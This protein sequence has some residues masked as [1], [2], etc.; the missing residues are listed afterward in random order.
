MTTILVSGL[1]NIETTLRVDGFP[2]LYSPV[3]Y[4]FWGV[5]AT[6]SGVGY[7]VAK[8]LTVLGDNVRFLSLI[9]DDIAATT[10]YD[11]LQVDGIRPGY[12]LATLEETPRSVILYDDTGKRQI[13]VDLK[14]VQE[15]IYPQAQ[16]ESAIAGCALA[17]LCNVNFSRPFLAQCRAR[18]IPIAT[19][20]HAIGDLE[21]EYDADFMAG[22]DILFMSHESLPCPPEEWLRRLWDRYGTPI[23][24]IGKGAEGALLGLKDSGRILTFPAVETRPRV[25]TVGAGDAMFSAFVHHYALTHDPEA[26][27]RRGVVFASYKIGETGASEGFLDAAGLEEWVKKTGG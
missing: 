15:H 23:A 26:A 8:A 21:S 27:L 12:V 14:D 5:R 18:G 13:N 2:I 4:P 11:Q 19:D 7:N 10:V 24:V 22:A 6:V 20:V 16:F 3:R 25:S 1:I 17:V 9:G